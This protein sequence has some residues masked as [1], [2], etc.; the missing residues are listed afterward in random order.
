[1]GLHPDG[2]DRRVRAAARSQLAE[3]LADVAVDGADVDRFDPVALGEREPLLD[4][5]ESDHARP[6]VQ[7]DPRA[8]LSDRSEPE[9]RDRALLGDRRELHRLPRGRKH[10]GEENEALVRRPLGNLD[11]AEVR[12]RDPHELR[13]TSRDLTVELCV[14]EQRATGP[15]LMVLRRLAL[16]VELTVAHPAGAAGDVEGDHYPVAG[17][18]VPDLGADGLDHSHRLVPEDVSGVQEWPEHLVEVQVRAADRGRGHPY[19]CV[20]RL[21]DRWIGHLLDADIAPALPG[22]RLHR[23]SSHALPALAVPAGESSNR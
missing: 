1:V 16:R 21:A 8:H 2:I 19:D 11:R 9:D 15:V 14:T 20:G 4:E 5:V 17:L 3:S 13:L 10:V 23:S 22:H 18:Q 6:P 7:G 12:V